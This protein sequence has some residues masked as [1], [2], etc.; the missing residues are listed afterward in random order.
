MAH[1]PKEREQRVI[2]RLRN[3]IELVIV[4]PRAPQR[5]AQKRRAGRRYHIVQ[6][7]ELRHPFVVRLII[8]NS[9]TLKPGCAHRI[10]R[11]VRQLIPR[12]LF[13][14]KPL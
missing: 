2:I 12:D 13:H 11:P 6:R 14:H 3:W 8:K 10:R 5:Q 9:E 4:T 7:I 1:S